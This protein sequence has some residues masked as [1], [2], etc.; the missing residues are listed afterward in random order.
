MP[1]LPA[2][3][4]VAALVVATSVTILIHVIPRAAG[5][6]PV[7]YP[8]TSFTAIGGSYTAY[9]YSADDVSVSSNVTASFYVAGLPM[10]PY[11][12][13]SEALPPNA[14]VTLSY[15]DP[16]VGSNV[17]AY[18]YTD[19]AGGV[20]YRMG[21]EGAMGRCVVYL[22]GSVPALAYTT[23]AGTVIVVP[24]YTKLVV[25]ADGSGVKVYYPPVSSSPIITC[26]HA[27]SYANATG[28]SHRIGSVNVAI[29]IGGKSIS[30]VVRPIAVAAVSPTAD[31]RITITAS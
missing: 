8:G 18:V 17:N 14:S 11:L 10:L 4:L 2:L 5:A 30:A 28:Y 25:V 1:R 20:Y 15:Y 31:A 21:G 27:L 12:A 3:A 19:S 26:A 22:I 16:L 6:P 24:D 23:G 7:V 9:A 13:L 29:M